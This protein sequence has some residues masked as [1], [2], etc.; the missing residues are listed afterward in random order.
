MPDFVKY[1]II[2]ILRIFFKLPFSKRFFLFFYHHLVMKFKLLK[3]KRKLLTL[4]DNIV[5]NLKLDDWI[6]QQLFFLG[7]Y[8]NFELNCIKK[9]INKGDICIDVGANFGLYSLH[10]SKWVGDSGKVIAFEPFEENFKALVDNISLNKLTNVVAEKLA[11]SDRFEEICLSY[12]P[13]E[14]NLGMVSAFE[15]QGKKTEKAK[16]ISID[17]YIKNQSVESLKFVKIDIEGNEYKALVG[18]TATIKKFRPLIQLEIVDEILLQ[19]P[20]SKEDIFNFMKEVN[21][22]LVYPNE[23]SIKANPYSKNYLFAHQSQ[24]LN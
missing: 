2:I 24:I 10:L 7:S 14:N 22:R 5:I 16:A 19:T 12:N 1:L 9:F 11:I 21:Y 8:E 4:N 18:M 23:H 15:V 3:G 6:Q 20:F 13:E 17:E